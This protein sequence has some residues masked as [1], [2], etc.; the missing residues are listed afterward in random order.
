[1][2]I[3]VLGAGSLG[4]VFGGHLAEAGHDV[5]L[6]NRSPAYVDA[7][8][9]RGLRLC[10]GGDSRAI[11]TS[12]ATT[13]E[14]LGAVDLLI[15]LVKSTATEAALGAN[16][17]LVGPQT[18]VVSLQ[19]GIGHEEILARF[20]APSRVLIGK[21]YV[22]GLMTAP[23]EVTAGTRGKAT[24]FGSP[25]GQ[26]SAEVTALARVFTQAG[27]H[28]QARADIQTVIW[29]KL[30]VNVATGALS[31]ITR[32]PYG[33]L[34]AVPEVAA[35]AQAAVAEAMAVAQ[36]QGVALGFTSPEGPWLK[37]AEG[38][39]P[40]FKASML[41]SIERGQPTEIDFINGA[42]ARYG[43]RFAIPTP[44]NATLVAAVK[45]IEAGLKG[46]E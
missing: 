35:T 3:A 41:Q 15:V 24:Y 17:A 16:R 28:T 36:A 40:E 32:L 2:R 27:L 31:A 7:V 43:A 23:G 39:P 12:A 10:E 38:L 37:A 4:S 26:N 1:M 11:G 5:T 30:L 25:D 20:A 8:R 18:W 45:G 44:V 29:D 46:A 21:T 33:A 42:V 14:G 13:A 6:I 34:Y 9:A 22:G 19:N